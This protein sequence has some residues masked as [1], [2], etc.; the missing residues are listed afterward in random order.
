M[1][2]AMSIKVINGE[3]ERKHDNRRHNMKVKAQRVRQSVKKYITRSQSLYPHGETTNWQI[4]TSERGRVIVNI[5][6]YAIL[7]KTTS[8]IK[9]L[10]I[11]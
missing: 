11:Q 1:R 2:R 5:P 10:P 8:L 4:I 6:I 9:Q 3:C 7:R